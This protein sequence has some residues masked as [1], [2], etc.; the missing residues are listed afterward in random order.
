MIACRDPAVDRELD[1][2]EH[3]HPDQH[4]DPDHQDDD[5]GQRGDEPAEAAHE[6]GKDLCAD[7]CQEQWPGRPGRAEEGAARAHHEEQQMAA[8]DDLQEDGGLD[9]LLGR[10]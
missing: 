3:D 4:V 10:G 1:Q 7:D 9:L 5:P 6:N 8:G 2:V